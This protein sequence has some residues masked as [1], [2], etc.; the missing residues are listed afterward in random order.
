MN[1]NSPPRDVLEKHKI[2]KFLIENEAIMNW[3]ILQKCILMLILGAA[4]HVTWIIWTVC[5]EN[6]NCQVF[7]LFSQLL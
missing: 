3:N 5:C 2:T 1:K 4:V 7:E 6:I